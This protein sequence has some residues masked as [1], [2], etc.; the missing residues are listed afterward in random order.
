[1][2]VLIVMWICLQNL[3]ERYMDYL[4]INIIDKYEMSQIRNIYEDLYGKINEN[5]HEEVETAESL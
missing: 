3:N 5:L 1:M 4:K 2:G